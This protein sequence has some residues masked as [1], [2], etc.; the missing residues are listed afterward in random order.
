[1]NFVA[2]IGYGPDDLP[3]W[4]R[5]RSVY[6]NSVWSSL[7]RQNWTPANRIIVDFARKNV[8]IALPPNKSVIG[9]SGEFDLPVGAVPHSFGGAFD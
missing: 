1:M 2:I 9:P 4:A 8:T 6:H 5:Q 7:H 3:I